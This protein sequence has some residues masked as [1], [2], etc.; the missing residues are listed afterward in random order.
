MAFASACAA[1]DTAP[2]PSQLHI[3]GTLSGLVCRDED[4]DIGMYAAVTGKVVVMTR[5]TEAENELCMVTVIHRH[6]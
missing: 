6:L 5:V 1:F 3:S 2:Q 4:W